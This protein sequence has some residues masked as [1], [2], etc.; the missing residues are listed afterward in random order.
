MGWHRDSW[1][2]GRMVGRMVPMGGTL[3]Q[4]ERCSDSGD[5]VPGGK[6]APSGK[7]APGGKDA[8]PQQQGGD[9]WNTPSWLS[10]CEGRAVTV[11]FGVVIMQA[12]FCLIFISS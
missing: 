5:D 4:Q 6:D 9:T 1:T 10:C 11:C 3:G 7:D 8:Q 2:V 12:E